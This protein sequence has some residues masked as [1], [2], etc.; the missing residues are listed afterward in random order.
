MVTKSFTIT[1]PFDL[2]RTARATGSTLIEGDGS[3]WHTMET[4]DGPGTI[5]IVRTDG[6]IDIEAWGRGG[7]LLVELAPRLLGLDDDPGRFDPGPGLLRDLHLRSRGL[8]LGST[9]RAF[10][11]LLSAVIGQLVTTTEAKSSQRRL[12][13]AI[14]RR[15]PGPKEGLRLPPTPEDLASLRYEQLHAFGIERKRA[16]TIIECARRAR[17][18]EE[19]M[20]MDPETARRRILS[21]RGVGPWTTE[22]VMGVAHGDRDAVPPGDH[23]LPHMI[24]WALAGEPRGSDER[25][26]ELLEPFRPLRRR[27]LIL[28]KQSGIK[29]P[30]YGPRSPL[31]THL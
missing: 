4:A 6:G 18:I 1:P 11:V 10:D 8:R 29:A 23:N 26:F 16:Q 17:R 20:E 25:M 24:S 13:G 21:I 27:V 12:E 31:R 19:A 14:G 7:S 5:H 3:V 9:G 2:R 30:R 15:A 28:V 22:T